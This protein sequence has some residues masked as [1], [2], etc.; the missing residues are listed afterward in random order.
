MHSAERPVISVV[1][2][3]RNRP[4]TLRACL[5]S[6]T[7][8]KSPHIEIVVQDNC[9]GPETHEI[10]VAAQQQ[11]A[12][13]TYWRAPYPT[14][15]RHNFELGLEAATGDNFTIIGDDD[16][17]CLGSLDWLAKH[18]KEEPVDA[19]RWRLIHYVWPSLSL[20]GEGF[21]RV[22]PSQFYGGWRYADP[23]AINEK[24]IN[25]S[26]AGS[27]EN[28]LVYH[29]MIS[30]KLYDRIRT[31]TEGIFFH[32]PLPDIYA[33]N[34]LSFHCDRYL[35]I[36]NPVSIYGTSGHSAGSSWARAAHETTAETTA[37][38][39]WIDESRDDPI[40]AQVDWQ[41]NIRTLRYHDFRTLKIAEEKGML[42][43]KVVDSDVWIAAILKEIE[44]NPW[45]LTPW[46]SATE[47]STFD[48][49]IFKAVRE[50]FAAL[51]K[52][53]PTAPGG[54][55]AAGSDGTALRVHRVDPN[56]TDDV[57]GAMLALRAT[58]IDGDM[59]YENPSPTAVKR[60]SILS[61]TASALI[62]VYGNL[63]A[64]VKGLLRRSGARHSVIESL[65]HWQL[66]DFAHG[67]GLTRSDK[68]AQKI[69]QIRRQK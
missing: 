27:W 13:I 28:I 22:Y 14:S 52:K 59:L 57:E 15:Q 56:L 17:F 32:Y 41:P 21:I 50:K 19:V 62:R 45:S 65:R 48:G 69:T 63:P 55:Y 26:N 20:D 18:L 42:A 7:H 39:Q 51:S 3:T 35:D 36:G 5:K 29:G 54:E 2:P 43:G 46:L 16:G 34:L 40:A 25:A 4:D 23:Q 64:P 44:L 10:V 66:R 33:H 31:K 1:I 60:R 53:I 67:D 61:R 8:H 58:L 11:D 9:S 30:R 37:G 47:R 49:P 68:L 24:T 6:L 38:Q 12:R